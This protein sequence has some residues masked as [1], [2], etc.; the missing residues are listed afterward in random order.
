M[1]GVRGIVRRWQAF[2]LEEVDA[3][4]LALFRILFGLY[5][6]WY[7]GRFAAHVELAFS[8]AGVPMP[9]GPAWVPPPPVAWA[10]YAA[11]LASAAAFAAGL[12]VRWT[13]P[14][15][16]LLFLHHDA[17]YLAARFSAFD[18]LVVL[19]LAVCC[20]APTDARWALLAARRDRIPAWAPRL[21][22]LQLVALYLGAGL[23][24]LQMPAWRSGEIVHHTLECMWATD[25]GFWVAR[26][27]IPG[28][29]YDLLAWGTTALELT[30]PALLVARRTRTLG[31]VLG[32]LFHVTLAVLLH[33]EEFL[34]CVVAYAVLWTPDPPRPAQG[35]AL[36]AGGSTM[37]RT[38]SSTV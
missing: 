30:L 8:D 27:P 31:V 32:T 20:A 1:S 15:L 38:P 12:S 29:A 5:L 3:R 28:R 37:H 9:Y 25:A 16:L 2:W 6:L 23:F 17:L 13:T 22:A 21:V 19:F 11:L 34:V 36:A 18:Q 33:V 4:G 14:A 24:K 7:F 10:L 26:Q 35:V